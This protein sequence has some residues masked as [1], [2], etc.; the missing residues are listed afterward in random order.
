MNFI[1]FACPRCCQH[2][3]CDSEAKGMQVE[4]PACKLAV[5]V[6]AAPVGVPLP[7]VISAVQHPPAVPP[8][9]AG[10]PAIHPPEQSRHG[11]PARS[12]GDTFTS[13]WT[14]NYEPSRP[15]K[16]ATSWACEECGTE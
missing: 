8:P 16:A 9:I 6:P 4:C 7:P 14:L 5:T 3:E 1:R 11:K 13:L 12:W 15:G 10:A 2:I